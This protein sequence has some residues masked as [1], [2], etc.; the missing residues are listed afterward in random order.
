MLK[1]KNII[2]YYPY[3]TVSAFG[4][5]IL[6]E[7][8][9][10]QVEKFLTTQHERDNETGL[11][12]RGARFYDSDVAR[13]LSLDPHA[14]RYPSF[15]DYSYVAGSPILFIDPSGKDPE[16]ASEELKETR[17]TENHT[18]LN[19]T[20]GDNYGFN[21]KISQNITQYPS[22][23]EL[24]ETFALS[25]KKE[26]YNYINTEGFAKIM[27]I[28]ADQTGQDRFAEF[29]LGTELTEQHMQ[30]RP[31]YVGKVVIV[32]SQLTSEYLISQDNPFGRVEGTW[33][34]HSIPEEYIPEHTY[35]NNGSVANPGLDPNNTPILKLGDGNGIMFVFR[36][37]VIPMF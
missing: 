26:I 2:N 12:Y 22:T 3:G 28:S 33:Q 30:D 27:E 21:E 11:D 34:K 37:A 31:R 16:S 13:F 24:M 36:V 15:S 17:W 19:E 29:L 35:S 14:N 1:Q 4:V 32:T 7:Y 25:A 23:S 9:D 6:R 10:G 18:R 5:E 20:F 8:T